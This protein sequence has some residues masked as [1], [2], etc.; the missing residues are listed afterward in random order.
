MQSCRPVS[1]PRRPQGG[2][3]GG[4]RGGM[5]YSRIVGTS[6]NTTPRRDWDRTRGAGALHP[7]HMCL[8]CDGDLVEV[9]DRFVVRERG[10]AEDDPVRRGG[11]H[12]RAE[13]V[14]ERGVRGG[15][16]DGR[17]EREERVVVG[18]KVEVEIR[19]MKC[20][21]VCVCRGR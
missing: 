1:C 3:L 8:A 5:V 14:D 9:L 12:E 11:V 21:D 7:P 18:R 13:E 2:V 19:V 20:W 15:L 6:S 10:D 16:A 4:Q 17:E